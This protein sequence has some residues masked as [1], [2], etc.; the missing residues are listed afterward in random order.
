MAV[1]KEP[2]HSF[3]YKLTLLFF[4][5]PF[6]VY[7]T[8][9]EVIRPEGVLPELEEV[10]WIIKKPGSGII[11]TIRDY[12][13]E[14]LVWLAERADYY[15]YLIR[16]S[17]PKLPIAFLSHGDEVS[18]LRKHPEKQY[19]KLHQYIQHWIKDYD[20]IFHVCGSMAHSLGLSEDSF[21][22]YIDVVPYGPSQV[23]DYLD[24]YYHHIEIELT[25]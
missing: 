20:V 18:S 17:H 25:W 4:L 16:K 12:D 22:D 19:I 1:T 7:A 3:L 2:M 5:L 15:L 13:E 11:F 10:E 8:L 24:L 9:P 23:K 21:P 14:A 6:N